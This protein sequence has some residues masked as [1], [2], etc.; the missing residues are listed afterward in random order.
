MITY[1]QL[2]QA[3][4]YQIE[5]LKKA[6]K[7]NKE[8]AEL[9]E[10]SAATIS[11]ELRRNGGENGYDAEEARAGAEQRKQQG[12]SRTKMTAQ[13]IQ[14]IRKG[15]LFDHSPEQVSGALKIEQGITGYLSQS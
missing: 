4:R 9:I 3:Q 12:K 10:T 14:Q 2:N 6:G 13:V 15:L 11:R 5:I 1:N 8:I 7:E